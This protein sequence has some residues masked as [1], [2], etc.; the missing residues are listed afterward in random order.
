MLKIENY[1]LD[2]KNLCSRK[3][4]EILKDAEWQ[5]ENQKLA[6]KDELSSRKHYLDQLNTLHEP[7]ALH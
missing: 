3:L 4:W 1:D 6:I 7:S 2:V 5:S